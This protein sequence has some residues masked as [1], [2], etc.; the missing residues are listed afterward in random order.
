MF[1][2]NRESRF[3]E[4]PRKLEKQFRKVI[5]PVDPFG[6]KRLFFC[7]SLTR[8]PKLGCLGIRIENRSTYPPEI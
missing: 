4:N 2:G 1:K 7:G 5:H 8:S 6:R 3:W